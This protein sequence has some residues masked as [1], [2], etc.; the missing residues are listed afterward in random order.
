MDPDVV[1]VPVAF[2]VQ[3]TCWGGGGGGGVLAGCSI[4]CTMYMCTLV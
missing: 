4:P 1:I 2:P 3:S